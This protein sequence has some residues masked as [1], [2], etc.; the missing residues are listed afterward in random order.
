VEDTQPKSQTQISKQ[1]DKPPSIAGECSAAPKSSTSA[2]NN[3]TALMNPSCKITQMKNNV[4]VFRSLVE[5]FCHNAGG[6]VP[7]ALILQNERIKMAY[8]SVAN[9][10]DSSTT[11]TMAEFLQE[12]TARYRTIVHNN[13]NIMATSRAYENHLVTWQ[14]KISPAGQQQ[15]AKLSMH[16]SS[17]LGQTGGGL[18]RGLGFEGSETPVTTLGQGIGNLPGATTTTSSS[19]TGSQAKLDEL[20][21]PGTTIK[22]PTLQELLLENQAQAA[23]ETV[24]KKRKEDLLEA[25]RKDHEELLKPDREHGRSKPTSNLA[26]LIRPPGIDE[27]TDKDLTTN[28]APQAKAHARGSTTGL[29]SVAA[30]SKSGRVL[31]PYSLDDASERTGGKNSVSPRGNIGGAQT[32]RPLNA[33]ATKPAHGMEVNRHFVSQTGNIRATLPGPP[34]PPANPPRA[35]D[36]SVKVAPVTSK[37]K[38]GMK[39]V[40]L[41]RQQEEESKDSYRK[42]AQVKRLSAQKT[43]TTAQGVTP[44]GGMMVPPPSG[45]QRRSR[46]DIA[47]E[48]DT[49][50]SSNQNVVTSGGSGITGSALQARVNVTP[51]HTGSALQA[52]VKIEK[53][54]HEEE[55]NAAGGGA[56]KPPQKQQQLPAEYLKALG[57]YRHQNDTSL[58]LVDTAMTVAD[59]LMKGSDGDFLAKLRMARKVRHDVEVDGKVRDKKWPPPSHDGYE[60]TLLQEAHSLGVDTSCPHMSPHNTGAATGNVFHTHQHP[61]AEYMRGPTGGSASAGDQGPKNGEKEKVVPLFVPCTYFVTRPIPNSFGKTNN[62]VTMLA[63]QA[64]G[65]PVNESGFPTRMLTP[66]EKVN[67]K[68]KEDQIESNGLEWGRVHCEEEASAGKNEAELRKER[69]T[70]FRKELREKNAGIEAARAHKESVE[71]EGRAAVYSAFS[72]AGAEE[73]QWQRESEMEELRRKAA[74]EAAIQRRAEVQAAMQ[75]TEEGEMEEFRRRETDAACPVV[76]SSEEVMKAAAR[77]REELMEEAAR[78]RGELPVKG[79]TDEE[80]AARM[81]EERLAAKRAA[82]E[83]AAK[84]REEYIERKR[85]ADEAAAK[86]RAE[87]LEKKRMA[88]EAAARRREEI[89]VAKRAKEAK[90][91]EEALAAKLAAEQKVEEERRKAEE[92]ADLRAAKTTKIGDIV[93]KGPEHWKDEDYSRAGVLEDMMKAAIFEIGRSKTGSQELDKIMNSPGVKARRAAL[94]GAPVSHLFKRCYPTVFKVKMH[95]QTQKVFICL[96]GLPQNTHIHRPE[97][98]PFPSGEHEEVF[99]EEWRILETSILN[100]TLKLTDDAGEENAASSAAN[101]DYST[102]AAAFEQG[103]HNIASSMPVTPSAPQPQFVPLKLNQAAATPSGGAAPMVEHQLRER[104]AKLGVSSLHCVTE[105]ELAKL[106]RETEANL[107]SAVC[108]LHGKKRTL[109]NLTPTAEGGLQCIVGNEC[110]TVRDTR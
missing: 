32:T 70:A 24:N 87:L 45:G 21:S 83:A 15:L 99:A 35:D 88:D 74:V 53:E 103:D 50:P 93:W 110:V 105:W 79:A 18:F 90:R 17:N 25:Q 49:T 10:Q 13:I 65:I 68:R 101:Q 47:G 85:A 84:R 4:M 91:K 94:V 36:L 20:V 72:K 54:A 41:T 69:I 100:G 14:K 81:R 34:P 51:G 7:V 1:N 5:T 73:E 71:A 19:M 48:K 30:V 33:D 107:S 58:L 89:L 39:A 92:E 16:M 62:E 22:E 37:A 80:A 63:L 108:A 3:I 29:G 77:K 106:L 11:V 109:V 9:H 75:G 55:N 31:R 43:T 44:A 57:R 2:K 42:F 97:R 67:L 66:M 40:I 26:K 78:R 59:A 95:K 61:S 56:E 28:N 23:Q 86:R 60:Q 104:L 27:S 98:M 76:R 102:V 8:K 46:W 64:I 82:D 12:D 38:P 52:R 96:L 6:L